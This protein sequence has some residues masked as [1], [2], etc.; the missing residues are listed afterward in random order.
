LLERSRRENECTVLSI[1]VNPT[2]FDQPDDLKKYPKT[3]ER[4]VELAHAAGVDFILAPTYEQMYPDSY[5][6]RVTE[7][8]FSTQLCGTSRPG[9]FDGVLSVV[10]KLLNL[11][12]AD[13]AYFG[14]KD[15]QQFKLIE[16]MAKAFFLETEIL[17]CPI[18][19]EA[20]GLAMSSRNVHLSP[21][22]RAK[23]ASLFRALKEA[24]T[25]QEARARLKLEGFEIDYIDDVN[26][27]RY[28]AVKLGG[29]RLI[30]NIE[31]G[32]GH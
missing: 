25:P 1:Y 21:E 20:D 18:I 23:A 24:S 7:N 5:S 12:Q 2:Q 30:D 31:L 10:L 15:F 14:E 22:A 6:Y 28:G 17:P 8:K 29:V 16:G 3:L 9:H 4:D 32:N 11:V 13:R 27:R 26:G 19:R